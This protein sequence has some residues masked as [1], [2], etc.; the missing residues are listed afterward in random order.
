MG[1]WNSVPLG[2]SGKWCGTHTSE[3]SY[4]EMRKL[5][6]LYTYSCWSLV[7]SLGGGVH[8]VI[9][10]FDLSI[11]CTWVKQT[12]F[13]QEIQEMVGGSWTCMHQNASASGQSGYNTSLIGFES[14]FCH[15]LVA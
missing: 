1:S 5:E 12:A 8:L 6:N 15:L 9:G 7:E 2:T 10:I 14:P 3:L 4:K 11:M 13:G